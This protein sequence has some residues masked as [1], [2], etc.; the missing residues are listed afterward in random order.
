[1]DDICQREKVNPQKAYKIA[2]NEMLLGFNFKGANCISYSLN[3]VRF[4]QG[5]SYNS[6]RLIE[7]ILSN[8]ISI[9]DINIAKISDLTR[10]I[11]PNG[12]TLLNL[13]IKT[14]TDNLLQLYKLIELIEKSRSDP[15]MKP[16]PFELIPDIHGCTALHE[17]V[18]KTFT[19][20]A[21]QI[22]S[23]LGK[24]PLDNH[25]KY[26][27]DIM[28]DLIGKCPMAMNKYFQERKIDCPWTLKQTQGN[29]KTADE[30]VEFGVFS[31][32]LVFIDEKEIED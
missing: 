7:M 17:C 19:R 4:L 2:Q 11:L 1:L 12:E 16:I 14:K 8:E 26:I 22:L 27:V 9:T 6:W 25:A 3:T 24:N 31:Y 32:P 30:D 15:D 21:D 23:L 20:A 5:F 10:Q 13:L 28:P 29:L 18:R